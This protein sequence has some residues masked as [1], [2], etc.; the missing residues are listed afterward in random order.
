MARLIVEGSPRIL[1]RSHLMQEA[2]R[3]LSDHD[4]EILGAVIV[5]GHSDDEIV[6]AVLGRQVH[7]ADRMASVAL[8]DQTTAGDSV[9]HLSWSDA[10]DE[11][12]SVS[13]SNRDS[14][15][16]G[17]CARSSGAVRRSYAV[18]HRRRGWPLAERLANA[19]LANLKVLL[20]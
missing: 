16:G 20:V 6:S 11:V 14:V 19:A 1:L 17:G 10:L 15:R 7:L 18:G 4:R 13:I 5:I 8:V 9:A 3:H 12:I 2:V